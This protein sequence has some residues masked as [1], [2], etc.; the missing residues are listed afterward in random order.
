[1][2]KYVY[3]LMFI[4]IAWLCSCGPSMKITGNQPDRISF[5]NPVEDS[6][7]YEIWVID[8]GFEIWFITNRKPIWYHELT[9]LENWNIRY[10]TAWNEKVMNVRFQLLYP[11]NPFEQR[12]NYQSFVDYGIDVNHKLFYYFKYVENTWGKVL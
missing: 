5:S 1:M 11:S 4:V 12:I 2:R 10:V 6:V 8:P 3:L 9:Y 7:E